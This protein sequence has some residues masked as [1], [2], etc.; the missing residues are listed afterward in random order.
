MKVFCCCWPHVNVSKWH[1]TAVR[2]TRTKGCMAVD[3]K[4]SHNQHWSNQ[5]THLS[6][7]R[8]SPRF[9]EP[10][11]YITHNS[12]SPLA[13]YIWTCRFHLLHTAT[14]VHHFFTVSLWAQNGTFF[15]KSYPPQAR[16]QKGSAGSYEPPPP[17]RSRWSAWSVFLI[18]IPQ[19]RL[20]QFF[21]V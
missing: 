11:S 3:R 18:C 10:A 16:N 2:P 8:A 12:S 14:I 19:G 15:R 20:S 17:T 13:T 6:I 21:I 4:T 1:D 9:I 7:W 5:V